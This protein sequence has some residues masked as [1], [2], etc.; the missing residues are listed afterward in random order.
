MSKPIVALTHPVTN[1]ASPALLEAITG[2]V[3]CAAAA[4]L[5]IDPS[6]LAARNKADRS[7]VTAAD[8]ASQATITA[9]L[10]RIAPSLPLVCEEAAGQPVPSRLGPTFALIDPLDGTRE[11]IGGRDEFTVNVA[12]VNDGVPILGVIAAP[13][14]GLIW[15]GLTGAGAERLRLAPGAPPGNAS[16]RA[17]IAPRPVPA[18]GLVAAI[19]RSHFDPATRAFLDRLAPTSRLECGSALKF[20]RV[21]EGAADIYPRLS[22]TSEWDVAAGHAILAAAGGVVTTPDG[23]ALTYGRST[24]KFIVPGFVAY[25]DPRLAGTF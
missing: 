8:L 21:A 11:F 15:R 5:A 25:G 12:I 9:G 3:S 19:S 18:K 22:P 17:V 24:E 16:E 14:L 23:R 20:C 4:I 7:P 1:P 13:A 6:R 10:A 2:L